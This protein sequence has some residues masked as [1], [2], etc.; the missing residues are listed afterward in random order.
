MIM[1]MIDALEFLLDLEV[2]SGKTMAMACEARVLEG[3]LMF[4]FEV[5]RFITRISI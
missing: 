4:K 3:T 2:T 1:I 5:I